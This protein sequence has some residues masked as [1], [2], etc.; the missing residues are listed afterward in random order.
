MRSRRD[1]R[2]SLEEANRT[3]P[4]VRAIVRD[5]VALS[6]QVAERREQIAYLVAGRDPSL[7]DVYGDELDEVQASLDRDARHLDRFVG[8]L[9]QL[10]VRPFDANVGAVDFPAQIEAGD[11]CYCWELGDSEVC[12]WRRPADEHRR[13]LVPETTGAAGESL[14]E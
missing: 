2:F 9:V 1:K 8:E 4:L 7:A 11:A 3:L 6:A 12:H 14:V 10:G 13:P 5:W